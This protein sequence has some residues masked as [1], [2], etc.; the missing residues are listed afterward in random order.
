MATGAAQAA[1]RLKENIMDFHKIWQEQCEA[2][3]GIQE[4]FG[5]KKAMGYLIGEKFLNHLKA[6]ETYKDFAGE[7]AAFVAEIRSI[8]QPYEI[9][10]Y[11]QTVRRVGAP[12]H[13]MTDE[14]YE[15][16]RHADAADNVVQGAE[17]VLLL[18]QAK[19]LLLDK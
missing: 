6:A 5:K 18:E 3:L 4:R 9:A 7:T 14:E 11:F 2:A 10:E 8:F 19:K 17:N 12:G 1:E 13:I 15:V 16:F